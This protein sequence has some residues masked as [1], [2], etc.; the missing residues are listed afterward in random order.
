MKHILVLLMAIALFAIPTDLSA[1][2]SRVS[3]QERAAQ[4]DTVL[5]CNSKYIAVFGDIQAYFSWYNNIP[6]Y[7]AAL[8]WIANHS[9]RIAF[10]LHTGDI[11]N[12]NSVPEW[13]DFYA[14][15]EP[16]ISIVPFYSCIGNHD[17]YCNASNPWIYRD[18]TRFSNYVGFPSTVSHIVSYFESGKYENVVVRENLDGEVVNL[19]LLEME[20]RTPVVKWA[21]EYVKTHADENFILVNHRYM[22]A[23]AKRY[24]NLNYMT[25]TVSKPGQYVWEN[26]VYNN[27]NIRCVLC[28][29]V[30]S[31][32]RV[33]YSTNSQ[34]RTVPQIE[35][36]IQHEPHGGNGLIQLWEFPK[37]DDNVYIRTFN[38]YQHEYVTDSITEYQFKYR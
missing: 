35:F 22:S 2:S 33:L 31:R 25:D 38:A 17:Y 3:K 28:G 20:P 7:R 27:D 8:E 1:Q 4:P 13:E 37:D 12:Y 32:T 15:T 9:D 6:F 26:L 5:N 23:N 18:S 10:S 24:R 29:H 19:L 14:A 16:Y 36:N 34:G 30:G 21:N 11:T